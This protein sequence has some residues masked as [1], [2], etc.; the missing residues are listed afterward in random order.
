M[1]VWFKRVLVGLV[2]IAIAA[3]VGIAIFLLTFDPNAYKDKVRDLVFERYQRTLSING[4][5]ELSLF[6]RIGLTVRDASLSQR[7]SD[8]VFA[9]FDSARVAVA[10]WPL[11]SNSL[12]VDHV[13]I[14]GFKAWV[15]RA[16]DGSLNLQ[17]LLSGGASDTLALAA[18]GVADAVKAAPIGDGGQEKRQF[19]LPG[20]QAGN[21]SEMHVD[22]AGL[23][24][25]NGAIHMLDQKSG[26][27]LNL[28][29]LDI[30]TGR[31]T[32]DQA[33][34]V[35]L[36]GRL[37]GDEPQ[38]DASIDAQAMLQFNPERKTYSAQRLSVQMAGR[39]PGFDAKQVS[40]RGNLGY[41]AY[42]QTL[43]VSSL[44]LLASGNIDGDHPIQN[45]NASLVVPQLDFNRSQMDLQLEKLALRVRGVRQKDNFEL[46]LDAPKLMM[47]PQSAAGD[48]VTGML[49]LEGEQTLG[50][51]M[52]FGGIGGSALQPSAREFRV[53]GQLQQGRRLTRLNLS[54][55]VQWKI[56]QR[57]GGLSAIKGDLRID[58]EILEGGSFE[59]PMIGSLALDLE[60]DQLRADINAV[61]DGSKVDFRLRATELDVPRS[62][63][64]LSA[65]ELNLD[66]FLGSDEA[67]AGEAP[68]DTEKSAKE[69]DEGKEA[70]AEDGSAKEQPPAAAPV[71]LR[72]PLLDTMDV[73]GE[74]DIG[75]L[76]WRDLLLSDVKAAIKAGG[77]RFN[78]SQASA[79]LYDGTFKGEFSLTTDAAVQAK[80]ALAQVNIEALSQAA[81][82]SSPLASK[83]SL[84]FDL[85][86]SVADPQDWMRTLGGNAQLKMRDGALKG[87]NLL[88][89]L[90][91]INEAIR[92]SFR[93]PIE[94]PASGGQAGSRTAFTSLDSNLALE[95]GVATVKS[96]NVAAPY[97]RIR[98]GKPARIA[99]ADRSLDV[100]FNVTVVNT[101]TGQDGQSLRALQGV[102]IPVRLH[103]AMTSP[104]YEIRWKEIGSKAVQQAVKGGLLDIV[105]EALPVPATP[106]KNA[107][108]PQRPG[109]PEKEKDGTKETVRAIG[110]A[111]KG[112][113]H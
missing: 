54:S 35:V 11:L 29:D 58:D 26:V 25:R 69:K 100:A 50:L 78:V 95:K 97:L 104:D 4:D 65:D 92:T 1:T 37:S 36:K 112:L 31:I 81:T 71:P 3:L 90:R 42:A 48:A 85:K 73:K 44:E 68:E 103:G 80:G 16:D 6:P 111:I 105:R 57:S 51:N 28:L 96:L 56:L 63:F 84:T 64:T 94:L 91:G 14:A 30:K 13:S 9:S 45:F 53:E 109:E 66:P 38:A 47:A 93:V 22:I 102:T 49:K 113:L 98:E 34:D 86:G 72:F 107:A 79:N 43:N 77:G 99:L 101:G 75:E 7:N 39:L 20:L 41:S 74:L 110:Q 52:S 18:A 40:L 8:T 27:A 17:D 32:S 87:I 46:A 33:F 59:F 24:L 76:R 108:Q 55:P 23:D 12:V 19:S 5:I 88:Q 70:P 15:E 89:A 10:I 82:G 60:K 62:T 21:V 83:G 2:A 67:A 61:L 106:E